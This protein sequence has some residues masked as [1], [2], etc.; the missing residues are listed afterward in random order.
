MSRWC[1][2]STRRSR[3]RRC[4]PTWRFML[5]HPAHLVALGFGCGLAPRRARHLGTLWAWLAFLVLQH[6]LRRRARQG[7]RWLSLPLGW[8]ACTVTARHMRVLDPGSIVWDEIV[9]VLAR[10]V[11]ADARG[12]AGAAGCLRAVPLLRRG[13]ARA[14]WPGPTACSSGFGWRGGFGILF[15]DL[16]AA[17][18]TLLVL[19]LVEALRMNDDDRAPVRAS[20]RDVLLARGWMLATAESCTG[21]HDRGRLHRPGRLQPVV[22]ARL[23]HLFQRGQDRVAGRRSGADRARMARSARWS[24]ARWPSARSAIR[25]RRSAWP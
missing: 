3:P 12:L 24:R 15:D 18:C 8:W 7:D 6:W 14:R 5:S 9:C 20:W 17:F 25:T 2:P 11:G 23:R 10:A 1:R 13:Q 22:R 16:V 4:G 19:A 21:G